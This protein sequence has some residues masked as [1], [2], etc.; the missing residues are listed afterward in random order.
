MSQRR[1]QNVMRS[2]CADLRIDDA[3]RRDLRAQAA[4]DAAA[5]G[6]DYQALLGHSSKRMSDRY[7]KLRRTINAPTLGRNIR[8]D[9]LQ[10]FAREPLN[11]KDTRVKAD[12]TPVTYRSRSAPQPRIG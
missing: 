12:Y 9:E 7:L 3:T 2:I 6:L 10:T 4:T 8:L 5:E 1:W 11:A